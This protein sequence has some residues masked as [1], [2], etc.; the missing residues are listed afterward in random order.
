MVRKFDRR[1]ILLGDFLHFVE[2]VVDGD[3]LLRREL[4]KGVPDRLVRGCL[5]ECYPAEG[6]PQVQDEG[7]AARVVSSILVALVVPAQ[8]IVVVRPVRFRHDEHAIVVSRKSATNGNALV[9]EKQKE[10]YTVSPTSRRED[11][12]GALCREN[13]FIFCTSRAGRNRI[14]AI[15]GSRIPPSNVSMELNNKIKSI[16]V[17]TRLGIGTKPLDLL[18]IRELCR[19]SFCFSC[20]FFTDVSSQSQGT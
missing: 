13:H 7:R 1:G 14:R 5:P 12:H 8:Q 9:Y 10:H 19:L 6:R 3:V 20:L 18:S 11:R 2:S 16:Y 15:E 4:V 17:F